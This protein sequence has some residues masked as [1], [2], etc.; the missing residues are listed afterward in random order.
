MP[1]S[2]F[3]DP[4]EVSAPSSPRRMTTTHCLGYLADLN[5]MP[6]TACFSYPADVPPRSGRHDAAELASPELHRMSYTTCFR[7]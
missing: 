2:C 7:Y 5:R 3:S 1:F 6:N 4:S